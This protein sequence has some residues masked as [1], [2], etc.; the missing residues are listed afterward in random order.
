MVFTLFRRSSVAAMISASLGGSVAM[1]ADASLPG[2]A[3]SLRESY[4]D[5][6][7]NCAVTGQGSQARKA[8]AMQ[9]EQKDAK[10]GQRVVAMEL[11]TSP[12]SNVATF[13]LPFGLDLAA[14]ATLQIDDGA[15]GQVLPF[16]TCLPAGC[17]VSS[18]IEPRMLASLRNATS[19]KIYAKAD[20]GRDMMFPLSLSG[21][22]SAYDRT[23]SLAK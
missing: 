18:N 15:K 13:I 9:Q 22:G 16:R 1:A 11:R 12:G 8:C 10:S 21:F 4:G 7:V 2:G 3:S 17:V 6:L 19:L 14:G 23:V 5:W 20:G